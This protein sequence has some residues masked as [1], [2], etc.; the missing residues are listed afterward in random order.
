[1]TAKEVPASA[2]FVNAGAPVAIAIDAN[3]AANHDRG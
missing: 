1:M 2:R 3:R